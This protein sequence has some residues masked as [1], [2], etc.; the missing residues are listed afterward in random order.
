MTT[1]LWFPAPKATLKMSIKPQPHTP[2]NMLPEYPV[3]LLDF[4]RMFPDEA[5]C[6][7]YLEKICW[8]NG[9]VCKKCAA[10]GEPF[11]LSSHPRKLKCR[12]CHHVESV[13]ADTVMH[14]SKTNIHVWFWAA[15][16][17]ATQTPGIPALELQKK[18]G[19]K[20]YETAFQI[21][22]KLRDA[23]VRPDRD[24]IGVEWPIE[25][26]VV[27][28]GGKTR[29]GVQGKTKQVPVIIA[30]EIRRQELR[31]D[32]T[33]NVIKRA[34]AGRIRM[35]HL[36]NKTAAAVDQFVSDCI[37]HGAMITSD[38]GKEFTNL[39]SLGYEHRPIPMRGDRAKM[40]RYLP[41]VSRITANLKTWID[42]TF[43]GVQNYHLQTCLNE[44][45]FRFNR[46][47]FRAISFLSLI[48][49]GV[50]RSGLTYR[51]VYYG[52]AARENPTKT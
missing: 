37:A 28:V 25:L 33:N 51:E 47:F 5:S 1:G 29:S 49:L 15:Y 42:G 14:R 22:H 17:V 18:L 32:N 23:M 12:F 21:L 30:V 43:H 2:P 6:L 39:S 26:D 44:F 40:D 8:P 24:K 46:R 52:A 27:F 16:L 31:D 45:M 13:T 11:R 20:R 9:F 48:G 38:D 3:T 19:I 4:Q 35:Q 36:P 34:L 7:C 41:M 50:L 10:V